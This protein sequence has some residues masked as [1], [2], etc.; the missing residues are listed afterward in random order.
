M[1]S[2]DSSAM[3]DTWGRPPQAGQAAPLHSSR[4]GVATAARAVSRIGA[5]AT[6]TQNPSTGF[7]PG[8]VV[9]PGLD[10][11]LPLRA[12]SRRPAPGRRPSAAPATRC[13]A[14]RAP[15]RAA[16]ANGSSAATGPTAAAEIE[17]REAPGRH[18]QLGAGG[19]RAGGRHHR[20][21]GDPPGLEPQHRLP[22]GPAARP[23]RPRPRGGQELLDPGEAG[24]EVARTAPAAEGSE[25]TGRADGLR[26]DV[27]GRAGLPAVLDPEPGRVVPRGPGPGDPAGRHGRQ[28]PRE[29][30]GRHVHVDD[31]AADHEQEGGVVQEPGDVLPSAAARAARGTTAGGR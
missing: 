14:R 31:E 24:G 27:N 2:P 26:R 9:Q 29:H 7:R 11:G 6:R 30:H 17:E 4:P 16:T 21:H 23:R 1:N 28:R 3:T 15:V 25:V 13:P 10:Q 19:R 18:P 8:H 5:A 22:A 12:R 20:R